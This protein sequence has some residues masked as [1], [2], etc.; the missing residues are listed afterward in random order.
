[1]IM[2]GTLARK[3]CTYGLSVLVPQ[4]A[5]PA[6]LTAKIRT[7]AVMNASNPPS[8][9]DPSMYAVPARLYFFMPMV[10]DP[11]SMIAMKPI[12]TCRRSCRSLTHQAGAAGGGRDGEYGGG[13]RVWVWVG[14]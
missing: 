5:M 12:S 1:M 6:L 14:G 8:G 13:G 4:L 3:S 10:S 9:K 2:M 11:M 7:P